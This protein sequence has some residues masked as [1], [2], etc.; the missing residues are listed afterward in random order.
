MK[1][2]F[3]LGLALALLCSWHTAVADDD[4]P[5]SLPA[6][7]TTD[8]VLGL[9]GKIP[10]MELCLRGRPKALCTEPYPGWAK[11]GA[12]SR[13]AK[14]IADH[15]ETREEA[16]DATVYAI[17]ESGNEISVSGDGG[18]S[19][20]PWQLS[21]EQASPEVARDPERAIVVWLALARKSRLDCQK[22]PE[23]ERL[24]ELGS[25]SC[26]AGRDLARRRARLREKVLA[27]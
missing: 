8:D 1:Y 23:D 2:L 24:A 7:L 11:R 16:G 18:K 22:L 27:E 9:M 25:G 12:A 6:A 20:G 5:T 26:E 10:A 21:E 14:A 3:A 13:I 4:L 19:H 15:A 17:R